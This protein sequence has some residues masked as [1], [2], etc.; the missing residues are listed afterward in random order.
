MKQTAYKALSLTVGIHFFIMYALVFAP[1]NEWA[2]VKI[3]SIRSFYMAVIMVA[4]MVILMLTFMKD[5]YQNKRTNIAL[6]FLS[7]LIFILGFLAIRSQAFVGNKNF[8]NSMIPHHSAA[9]TMCEEANITDQELATLCENIIETQQEEINQM[10]S[11]LER[12]NNK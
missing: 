7:V 8:I 2:D 3:I 5:M 10:N 12:L 9:I 6:Y 4:P 11:I 1:V